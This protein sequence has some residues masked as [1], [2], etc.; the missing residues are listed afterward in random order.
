MASAGVGM[1]GLPELV[2]H[3][4]PGQWLGRANVD[5][6]LRVH[7]AEPGVLGQPDEVTFVEVQHGVGVRRL[8]GVVELLQ[9]GHQIGDGRDVVAVE[10]VW[11]PR[12]T[13]SG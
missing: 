3:G 8:D 6:Q 11:R 5:G 2:E 13:R 10:T 4:V 1:R 9:P 12:G 7:L